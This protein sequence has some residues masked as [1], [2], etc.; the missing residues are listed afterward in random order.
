[1]GGCWQRGPCSGLPISPWHSACGESQAFGLAAD[2]H[3]A[4]GP[5]NPDGLLVKVVMYGFL[6]CHAEFVFTP[7]LLVYSVICIFITSQFSY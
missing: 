3:S 7:T 1:M 6:V 2:H 4:L 5:G